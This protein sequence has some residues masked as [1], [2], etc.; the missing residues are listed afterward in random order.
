MKNCSTCKYWD[1]HTVGFIREVGVDDLEVESKSKIC[2]NAAVLSL[3]NMFTINPELGDSLAQTQIDFEQTHG[4]QEN[5][6]VFHTDEDFGCIYH[7]NK[8]S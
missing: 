6:F 8:P 1:G 4:D 3:V 5:T 7:E 2:D